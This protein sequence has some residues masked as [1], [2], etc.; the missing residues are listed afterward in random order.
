MKSTGAEMRYTTPA[1][2]CRLVRSNTEIQFYR[3]GSRMAG[4]RRDANIDFRV[5]LCDLN[6]R[7]IRDDSVVDRLGGLVAGSID[8]RDGIHLSASLGSIY[9]ADD[10]ARIQRC[11]RGRIRGSPAGDQS[12][13][14]IS[15]AECSCDRLVQ[16]I[17]NED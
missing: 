7:I 2:F 6:S 11:G 14:V 9:V 16:N 1:Q 4:N 5:L 10:R 15:A 8:S 12:R 3:T 13:A 17:V